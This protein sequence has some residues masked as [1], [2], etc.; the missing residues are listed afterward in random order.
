MIKLVRIDYRLLHGQVVFAWTR[1]LDIDYIIV[2]DKKAASDPFVTMSLNLAKPAGVTLDIA[3]VDQAA[4]KLNS[5]KLD[6]KKVMIVLGNTRE[7]LEL[8]EKVPGIDAVNFGGIAQKE[9]AQQFG[10]A[11]YLTSDEIADSRQMKERGIR[12][13]M[14]Q[15]PAHSAE[16]LNEKV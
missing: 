15:V 2:A 8:V 14:R 13:E 9:G 7:T 4:A 16:L 1:A 11:I 6:H 10:K 5:G 3:T 12:M